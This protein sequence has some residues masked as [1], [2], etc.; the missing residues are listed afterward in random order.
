MARDNCIVV[1]ERDRII[2]SAN[3]YDCHRFVEGQPAGRLHRAFSV[4]LFDS[5]NR[6]LLQQRAVDKITF[7][8]ARTTVPP[9]CFVPG[10]PCFPP[11]AGGGPASQQGPRDRSLAMAADTCTRAPKRSPSLQA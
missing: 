1:D 11:R 6:L 4:F 9:R 8:G 10:A 3:K 5:A 2:G 7:P